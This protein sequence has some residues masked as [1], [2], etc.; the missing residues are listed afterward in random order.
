LAAEEAKKGKFV[1]LDVYVMK[2]GMKML[3]NEKTKIK[4]F[5]SKARS[6]MRLRRGWREAYILD[7][8][9]E[10]SD[11][12]EKYLPFLMQIRR[13]TATSSASIVEQHSTRR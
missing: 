2:I 8:N 1:I 9:E 5:T 13:A 6:R 7:K 11:S 3:I 12:V 4:D 10:S